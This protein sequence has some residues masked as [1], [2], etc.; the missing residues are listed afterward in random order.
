MADK[1]KDWGGLNVNFQNLPPK[2]GDPP[3]LA[4]AK[5]MVVGLL[6]VGV[7]RLLGALI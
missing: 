6:I 2:A 7:M 1:P 3:L 4:W 5:M